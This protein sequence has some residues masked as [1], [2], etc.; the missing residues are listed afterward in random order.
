MSEENKKIEAIEKRLDLLES[1][2]IE[3]RC[4][5]K[6][7]FYAIGDRLD[8]L[9]ANN[10][11]QGD[12]I[13]KNDKG[14]TELNDIFENMCND[15]DERLNKIETK[16]KNPFMLSGNRALK[17]MILIEKLEQKIINEDYSDLLL[18]IKKI[19]EMIK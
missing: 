14:L 17:I 11:K 10:K 8:K 3:P 12:K 1:C 2:T 7:S 13:N 19:K 15:I 5:R 18:L 6:D 4:M 16:L 9:E